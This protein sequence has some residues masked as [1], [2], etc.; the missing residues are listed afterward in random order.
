[1]GGGIDASLA[2]PASDARPGNGRWGEETVPG[3]RGGGEDPR[4]IGSMVRD[5]AVAR[6][7][8]SMAGGRASMASGRHGRRTRA[9]LPRLPEP[10]AAMN[11]TPWTHGCDACDADAPVE[12][13]PPIGYLCEACRTPQRLAELRRELAATESDNG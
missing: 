3:M 6:L 13:V 12:Y 8:S 10:G 7:N 5:D 9:A 4:C 2:S 11:K 1:N